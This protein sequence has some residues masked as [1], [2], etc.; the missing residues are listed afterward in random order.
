MKASVYGIPDFPFGKKALPDE[1]L[2][3]L[4]ELYRSQKITQVQLEY[5]T[6]KDLK[7]ADAIVCPAERKLDLV[8]LDMEVLEARTQ[9]QLTDFERALVPARRSC[10]KKKFF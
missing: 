2:D 8:I 4:N 9:K 1:R 6:D 5:V 3:K 7:V 10:W